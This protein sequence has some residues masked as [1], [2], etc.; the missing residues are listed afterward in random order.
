MRPLEGFSSKQGVAG[1]SPAGPIS[2]QQLVE[3]RRAGEPHFT[4]RCTV[5]PPSFARL[6]DGDLL[7]R[8]FLS[9]HGRIR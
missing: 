6:I 5:A 7:L 2:N 1:S 8:G 3:T 9:C 4:V